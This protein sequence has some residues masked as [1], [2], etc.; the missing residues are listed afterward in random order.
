[1]MNGRNRKAV[2]DE[3]GKY[4]TFVCREAMW[5]AWP[6]MGGK[7]C[8]QDPDGVHGYGKTIPLA[9]KDADAKTRPI[10]VLAKAGK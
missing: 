10:A 9:I 5:Q 4:I 7:W 1:M 2:I 6:S 8:V 3:D